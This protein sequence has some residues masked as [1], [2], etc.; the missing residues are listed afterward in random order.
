MVPVQTGFSRLPGREKVYSRG[1]HFNMFL[2]GHKK[3]DP[4]TRIHGEVVI[5]HFHYSSPLP[6]SSSFTAACHHPP[7][8][9]PNLTSANGGMG[10]KSSYGD[11]F[12]G[13]PLVVWPTSGD[14]LPEKGGADAPAR[15]GPKAVIDFGRAMRQPGEAWRS[16]PQLSSVWFLCSSGWDLPATRGQQGSSSCDDMANGSAH[17]ERL[18]SRLRCS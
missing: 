2:N 10:F 17:R 3:N 8:P 13:A 12:H 14:R 15:Q 6:R 1:A 18:L 9:P 7:P 16:M 4:K 5:S 11:G